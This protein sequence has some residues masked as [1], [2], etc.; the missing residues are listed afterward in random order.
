LDLPK[1]FEFV[2][3]A[4][5]TEGESIGNYICTR[6][7]SSEIRIKFWWNSA[8]TLNISP[9]SASFYQTKLN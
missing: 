9:L 3:L 4:I 7:I 6:W 8:I 1:Y 2:L 5:F